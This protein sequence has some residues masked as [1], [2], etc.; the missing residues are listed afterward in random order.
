MREKCQK[1]SGQRLLEAARRRKL[2]RTKGTTVTGRDNVDK[3]KAVFSLFF[4]VPHFISV[5]VSPP[6]I[7]QRMEHPGDSVG[8]DE[9]AL[10]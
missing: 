10:P 3:M 7:T 6:K 9:T 1:L 2:P 4:F 5:A 8:D